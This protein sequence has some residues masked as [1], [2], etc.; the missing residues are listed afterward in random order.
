MFYYN[1]NEIKKRYIV[2]SSNSDEF[3]YN[4]SDGDYDI[5]IIVTDLMR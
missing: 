3:A 1:N 4:G 5:L 2:G